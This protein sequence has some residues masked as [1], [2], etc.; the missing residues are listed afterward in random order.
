MMNLLLSQQYFGGGLIG[1]VAEVA[2]ILLILGGIWY[3]FN[4][5]VQLPDKFKAV[6]NV[7]LLIILA[8]F[9]IRFLASL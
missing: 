3:I 5:V 2:I 6:A 1:S 9:A 4:S 8:V 7:V